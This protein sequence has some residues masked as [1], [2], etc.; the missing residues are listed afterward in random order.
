M[1]YLKRA[2]QFVFL[3]F[4][5]TGLWFSFHRILAGQDYSLE[6]EKI[7]FEGKESNRIDLTEFKSGA[8]DEI[9]IWYPYSDIRGFKVDGIYL[10]FESGNFNADEGNNILL[11]IK[12]NK[13]KGHAVFSRR[14][15]D[16]ATSDLGP[17][18]IARYKAVFKFN[19]T[20]DF[21]K[22]QFIEKNRVF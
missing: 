14:K 8:W 5:L 19:S 21:S 2:I 7:I 15:V 9:V 17:Q 16:F 20:V 11:F 4:A 10:L 3:V 18:R 22:V 1:A 6:I 12:D 13:I